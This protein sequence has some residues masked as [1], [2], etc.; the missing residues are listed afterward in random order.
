MSSLFSKP[1]GV[2]YVDMCIYIDKHIY[3][4]NRDDS[5][6]FKYMCLLG[7]MLAYRQRYF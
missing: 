1:T 4:E 3:E 7:K 2:R 5:T 6:I